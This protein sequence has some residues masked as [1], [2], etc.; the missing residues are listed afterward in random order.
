[1]KP[2][3]KTLLVILSISLVNCKKEDKSKLPSEISTL[4]VTEITATTAVCSGEIDDYWKDLIVGI[5][6][7]TDPNIIY[8]D[9]YN[10]YSVSQSQEKRFSC[11]MTNLIPN[12]KYYVRAYVANSYGTTKYGE[13]IEFTTLAD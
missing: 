2:I 5:C 1:M 3:L 12:T 4:E 7:S 10:S 6:W 9:I 13:Q 11:E 8:D